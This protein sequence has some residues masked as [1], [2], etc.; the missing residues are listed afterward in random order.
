MKKKIKI[1][2]ICLIISLILLPP[3]ISKA[4]SGWD[5][6]YDSGG[7][8]SSSGGYYDSWG[9]SSSSSSYGGGSSGGSLF[10]PFFS[11]ATTILLGL[12]LTIESFKKNRSYKGIPPIENPALE[13]I[14]KHKNSFKI[15]NNKKKDKY[16]IIGYNDI[17]Q[18]KIDE[19]DSSVKI[20]EF[21][22]Q[23]FNIY[24][25]IQ[26][27]WM[28]FDTDT[29]RKLTTD[30]IY[31]MYSSQLETL[32][33]KHQKNI[34]KNIEYVDAKITNIKLSDDVISVVVFLRVKCLD[35]VINEKTNK[36]VRGSDS[37]RLDIQYL[38]TFVKSK[39]NNNETEKCPNCGAP[40]D[41]VSSATCPYCKSTLVK[42]ASNYVLSKKT[43]IGQRYD[44]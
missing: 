33:L 40:V 32:K 16:C 37:T 35:Y 7:G 17:E 25:D 27:A 15:K 39:S 10:S 23:A 18:S 1:T 3:I 19:I 44:K 11:I 36:T 12:V 6:S 24:K 2:G 4:D 21:K 29:I 20:E 41:I 14:N 22:H 5:S 31:N 38:L 30:E 26:E 28:N 8:W 34:M 42:D 9:S 13:S 43:C